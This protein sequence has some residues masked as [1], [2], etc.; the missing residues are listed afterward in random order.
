MRTHSTATNEHQQQ[1]QQQLL[2]NPIK[3]HVLMGVSVMNLWKSESK[4]R[5][6]RKQFSEFFSTNFNISSTK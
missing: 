6:K 1:L 4:F 5:E 3:G 2:V